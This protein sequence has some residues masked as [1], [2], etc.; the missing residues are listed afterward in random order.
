MAVATRVHYR[1]GNVGLESDVAHA[2]SV[3]CRHSCR[4]STGWREG[5]AQQRDV[6]PGRSESLVWDSLLARG[7]RPRRVQAGLKAYV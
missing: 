7:K 5:P 4:H 1:F 2:F 3:P 6:A